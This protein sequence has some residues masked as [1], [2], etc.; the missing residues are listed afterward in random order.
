[1]KE[2]IKSFLELIYP[3]KNI[4]QVCNT[5]DENIGENYICKSCLSKLERIN[6]PFCIK[7]NKSLDEG[8]DNDLCPEC[9]RKERYF[10]QLRSPFYYKGIVKK[11]IHDYKYCNKPYYYKLF[12]KLL[13]DYMRSIDY[14]NFDYIISVPLHKIKLRKRGYNQSMLIAK[15]LS[16]RLSIPYLD[17]LKRVTNTTKQSELSKSA[18]QQNIINAFEVKNNKSL[19]LIDDKNILLIDDI[20]TTGATINECTKLLMKYGAKNIYVLTISR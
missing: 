4:C 11:Y 19:S 15:Y 14:T 13:L 6:P 20:Y 3:E 16:K 8:A 2:V 5:Y 9:I 12:G 17:I 10:K 18:R 1:M 7:C